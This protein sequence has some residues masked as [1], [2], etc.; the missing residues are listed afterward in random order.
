MWQ[1]VFFLSF[2]VKF[3]VSA[4][5]NLNQRN[6]QVRKRLIW[7]ANGQPEEGI[8]LFLYGENG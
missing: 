1:H 3:P 5:G 6:K 2:Y 8:Q 4:V 7:V